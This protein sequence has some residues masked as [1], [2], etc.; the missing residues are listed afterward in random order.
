MT[1]DGWTTSLVQGVLGIKVSY[2]DENFNYMV[3]T[4]AIERLE[5]RHTAYSIEMIV[6]RV[7]D[8]CGLLGKVILQI[9]F[10]APVPNEVNENCSCY[11]KPI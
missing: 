4:L 3:D 9:Y 7:L 5:G 6:R 8:K 1:L 2:V 11:K 10:I